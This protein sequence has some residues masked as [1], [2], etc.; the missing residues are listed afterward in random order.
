MKAKEEI[1]SLQIRTKT[2]TKQRN[3]KRKKNRKSTDMSEMPTQIFHS[4]MQSS[5]QQS[6][7]LT[8]D[9]F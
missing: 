8:V 2:K 1:D 5:E 4:W 3:K 7:A 6:N 9:Q